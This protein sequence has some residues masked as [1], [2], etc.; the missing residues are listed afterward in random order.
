MRDRKRTSKRKNVCSRKVYKFLSTFFN[1]TYIY[2]CEFKNIPVKI[3]TSVFSKT[4]QCIEKL[5]EKH[6]H[7]RYL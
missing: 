7:Q 1:K 5:Q 4:M 2:F 6:L 3:K